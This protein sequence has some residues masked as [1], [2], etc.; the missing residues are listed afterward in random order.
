MI[1]YLARLAMI[2]AS[3]AS[4]SSS[5]LRWIARAVLTFSLAVSRCRSTLLPPP[6]SLFLTLFSS[7]AGARIRIRDPEVTT[8][9]S[10]P[11]RSPTRRLHVRRNEGLRGDAL[12]P[13]RTTGEPLP[14]SRRESLG[15][16]PTEDSHYPAAR[17]EKG[18][19]GGAEGQRWRA[20]VVLA[21]QRVPKL[22]E[23]AFSAWRR[24]P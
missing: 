10:A 21:R 1:A 18:A 22:E 14:L 24:Q 20:V 9:S 15:P 8:A 17:D 7:C 11:P 19:S 6:P 2:V 5:V 13:A 4:T 3:H 16:F 12:R 23:S